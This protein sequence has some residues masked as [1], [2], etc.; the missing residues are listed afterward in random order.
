[1][2]WPC[3]AFELKVHLFGEID[4]KLKH[5]KK[6]ICNLPGRRPFT[7]KVSERAR[8]GRLKGGIQEL[9][10]SYTDGINIIAVINLK[11]LDR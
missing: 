11:E 5:D 7:A 10:K 6:F 2:P 3:L 9:G 1:M 4:Q 8:Q